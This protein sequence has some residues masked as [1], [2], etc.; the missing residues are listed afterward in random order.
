MDCGGGR[1]VLER[2]S[3]AVALYGSPQATHVDLSL[4]ANHADLSL[5]AIA[6]LQ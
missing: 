2:G 6:G 3:R 1:A 4:Q 5:Q